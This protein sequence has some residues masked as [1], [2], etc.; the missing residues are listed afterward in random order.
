MSNE[1]MRL[2]AMAAGGTGLLLVLAAVL[3]ERQAGGER[4]PLRRKGDGGEVSPASRRAADLV[5]R[6]P[7]IRRHATNVRTLLFLSGSVPE[8]RLQTRA[9]GLAAFSVLASAAAFLLLA[10]AYRME[11]FLLL[12]LFILAAGMPELI[13][14]MLVGTADSRIL[15]S[16][17][18]YLGDVKHHYHA[19]GMVDESLKRAN[20]RAGGEMLSQGI[21]LVDMLSDAHPERQLRRY[22]ETCGIRFLKLF[23]AFSHLV[24]EYGDRKQDGSSL[25]IRNIN[26]L[27]EEIQMEIVKQSQLSYWL[28]GL[29]AIALLPL[30]FPPLIRNWVSNSFPVVEAF[31]SGKTAFWIVCVLFLVAALCNL[32]IR[33]IQKSE[34]GLQDIGAD[35]QDSSSH[36]LR[37]RRLR[38]STTTVVL[39]WIGAW[40]APRRNGKEWRRLAVALEEAGA[41]ESVGNYCA[42]RFLCG[43][44]GA[45]I[46]LAV[47]A[48]GH[49]VECRRIVADNWHGVKDAPFLLMTGASDKELV[50]GVSIAD[51]DAQTVGRWRSRA[52]GLE[53][54]TLA[55]QLRQ[56]YASFGLDGEK[57]D[58]AI[59]RAVAKLRSVEAERI[60][61]P[62]LLACMTTGFL[63]TFIPWGLLHFRSVMR[64]IDM[65]QEVYLFHTIVLL[66][67][68]HESADVSVVLGWMRDF[69]RVFRT[70]IE[71]CLTG[72]QHSRIALERL[73]SATRFK[74]FIKIVENLMMASEDIDVRTAF[75]NLETERNFY[76]E[77]R[78]EA[79]RQQV[80]RKVAWGQM[81]GFIPI[82]AVVVLY[83]VVP[84]VVS[85]FSAFDAIRGQL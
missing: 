63:A 53:D 50:T 1:M 61:I 15:V 19:T 62:G 46:A 52:R 51:A 67:M 31:Y 45:L 41:D 35:S 75:D 22:V 37:G 23:A 56:E 33:E 21:L 79:N 57:L 25:Y 42:K 11:P 69:A 81:I 49:A 47:I 17:L 9:A 72:L 55:Q 27:M 24:R 80:S 82:H 65:E 70:P 4:D 6:L 13:V 32:F 28:R 20:L 83:M 7:M 8:H 18:D 29:N 43:V 38:G 12:A 71:I 58:A 48:A 84:M 64:R 74:P 66:L 10:Q 3:L 39:E 2:A 30:L 77:N 16:L 44:A 14:R 26:H 76:R 5:F 85:S 36:F 59:S 60:G 40:C 68:H 34:F 54:E 78:K 73:R